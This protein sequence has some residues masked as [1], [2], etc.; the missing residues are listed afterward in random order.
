MAHK[1]CVAVYRGQRVR[2]LPGGLANVS[3]LGPALR[4]EIAGLRRRVLVVG[5]LGVALLVVAAGVEFVSGVRGFVWPIALA[6]AFG[7][8]WVL[9][10]ALLAYRAESAAAH[11]DLIEGA[12]CR[13]TG[14]ARLDAV[15]PPLV[16]AVPHADAQPPR[17]RL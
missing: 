1:R 8:L 12:V 16:G 9:G 2:T 17:Y 15:A 5:G 3:G 4:R 10:R 13:I 14:P 7:G 6:L 11:D